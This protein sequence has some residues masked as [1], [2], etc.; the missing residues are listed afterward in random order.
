[1]QAASV[2]GLAVFYCGL[3]DLHAMHTTASFPSL[4]VRLFIGT[5]LY[6]GARCYPGTR[7]YTATRTL[8]P[9]SSLGFCVSV[10]NARDTHAFLT[11]A[12]MRQPV[13]LRSRSSL[14]DSDPYPI[15]DIAKPLALRHHGMH[16]Y[17][18][19]RAMA[20]LARLA[21]LAAAAASQQPSGVNPSDDQDQDQDQDQDLRG[22]EGGDI[23]NAPILSPPPAPSIVE[24]A[25]RKAAFKFKRAMGVGSRRFVTCCYIT[26]AQAHVAI[27]ASYH[28]GC[29]C[30]MAGINAT[31]TVSKLKGCSSYTEPRTCCLTAQGIMPTA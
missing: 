31:E 13:L 1:V 24:S 17:A 21:R 4:A 30:C 26:A 20:R 15:L 19:P 29:V 22:G 25:Y 8:L 11:A 10:R 14:L 27:H 5:R 18:H 16:A 23:A 2:R 7:L 3:V 6:T 9:V 12:A 28:D